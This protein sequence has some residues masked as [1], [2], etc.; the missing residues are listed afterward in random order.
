M[1]ILIF[2]IRSEETMLYLCVERQEISL[3]GMCMLRTKPFAYL[4]YR[5]VRILLVD[6]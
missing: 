5:A 1:M 2:I 3:S 6:K 4:L